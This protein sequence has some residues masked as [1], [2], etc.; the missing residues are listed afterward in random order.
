LPDLPPGL[1]PGTPGDLLRRRPDVAA[2]EA[3]LDAAGERVGVAKADR[4]PRF[5]LGGLIGGQAVDAGSL[6]NRDGEN[7]LVF[8]GIDWSFLDVGRVRARID[9]SRADSEGEQARYEQTILRALEETENAL[10]GY[11]QSRREDEQLTLAAAGSSDAV[12]LARIRYEAGV[13]DL[14]EVLDAERTHLLAQDAAAQGRTRSYSN[15]VALYKA[16][17]GGWPNRRPSSSLAATADGSDGPH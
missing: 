7:R 5:T 9:A 2:A 15:L 12:R 4:F 8:L 17:A 6:F 13:I 10:V 1:D 14:F 11:G 16:M 3:R